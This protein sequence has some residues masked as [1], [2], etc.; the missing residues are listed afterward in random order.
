MSSS[1][2]INIFQRGWNHQPDIYSYIILYQLY[3]LPTAWIRHQLDMSYSQNLRQW[4]V[5]FEASLFFGNWAEAWKTIIHSSKTITC[6]YVDLGHQSS[7]VL[8]RKLFNVFRMREANG[9][10]FFLSIDVWW[11]FAFGSHFG[12]D[13]CWSS[14]YPVAM[15]APDHCMVNLCAAD[16]RPAVWSAK[17]RVWTS[18]CVAWR[19]MCFLQPHR[20]SFRKLSSLALNHERSQELK[21]S[22]SLLN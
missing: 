20:H 22:H 7:C 8:R 12:S 17:Y 19:Q 6:A 21:V 1:Q 15:Q 5:V 4:K 16:M 11:W 18:T 10:T 2:L 9:K 14:M 13:I 3:L